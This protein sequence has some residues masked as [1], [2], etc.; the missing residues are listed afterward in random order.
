MVDLFSVI[1]CDH[2]KTAL[3]V[4]HGEKMVRLRCASGTELIKGIA[5]KEMIRSSSDKRVHKLGSKR[6]MKRVALIFDSSLISC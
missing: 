2:Y 1:I 6:L 3:M 5:T 4:L